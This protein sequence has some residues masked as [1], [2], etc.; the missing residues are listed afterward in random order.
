[1]KDVPAYSVVAG[2][3]A[4]ILK[5]RFSPEVIAKLTQIEISS[6]DKDKIKQ[7]YDLIQKEELSV[8]DLQKYGS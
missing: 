1:M 7:L 8:V 3:P 6:F 2:N 4:K 5:Y